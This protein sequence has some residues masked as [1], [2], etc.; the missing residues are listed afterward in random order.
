ML[1]IQEQQQPL[2]TIYQKWLYKGI[3]HC[4]YNGPLYNSNHCLKF[5]KNINLLN[6]QNN[7]TNR[8]TEAKRGNL[9]KSKLVS[10]LEFK[11]RWSGSRVCA[12]GHYDCVVTSPS[13]W[14]W[15]TGM[16]RCIHVSLPEAYEFTHKVVEDTEAIFSPKF[17]MLP[18]IRLDHVLSL[19]PFFSNVT[20][21]IHK[22]Y[23]YTTGPELFSVVLS[24]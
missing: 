17:N 4:L 2:L 11:S 15:T 1:G 5:F 23:M 16:I 20:T 24:L 18:G 6:T 14:S 19:F 9:F 3:P 13:G 21:H 12:L 8:E 10:A 7:L 22:T